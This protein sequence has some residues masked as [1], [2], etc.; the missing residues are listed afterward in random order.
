MEAC[1]RT[2]L[3]SLLYTPKIKHSLIKFAICLG[4]K[5]T[6]ALTC[7]CNNSSLVYRS[8]ICALD[9][10]IP[11]VPKSITNWYAGLRAFGNSWTSIMVPILRS[12]FRKSSNDVYSDTCFI[13]LKKV[14]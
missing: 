10:F 1:K 3:P 6:T 12:T 7:L 11:I 4:L 5:L 9:F 8:V 2:T 14:F 13:F